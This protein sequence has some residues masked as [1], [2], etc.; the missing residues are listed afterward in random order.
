MI[1]AQALELAF[2]EERQL[3]G[4]IAPGLALSYQPREY[5]AIGRADRQPD[6]DDI[7]LVITLAR[8]AFIFLASEPQHEVIKPNGITWYLARWSLKRE[9]VADHLPQR[10]MERRDR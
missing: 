5:L 7:A 2:R 8:E 10:K 9:S 3:K 6:A 1:S 4:F